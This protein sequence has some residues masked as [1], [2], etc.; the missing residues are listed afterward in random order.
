MA[1]SPTKKG[2]WSKRPR[3]GGAHGG[4]KR[5]LFFS[6]LVVAVKRSQAKSQGPVWGPGTFSMGNNS[7]KLCPFYKCNWFPNAG[8]AKSQAPT[9]LHDL[10]FL[11]NH[12]ESA[13]WTSEAQRSPRDS[14][15]AAVQRLSGSPSAASRTPR[16]WRAQGRW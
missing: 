11:T 2:T 3:R 14:V 1:T 8:Q 9:A 5:R 6:G 15:P 10:P 7:V 13:S 12:S 16:W 4:H